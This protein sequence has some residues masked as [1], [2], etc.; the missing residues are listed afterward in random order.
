MKATFRFFTVPV[1]SYLSTRCLI[2]LLSQILRNIYQCLKCLPWELITQYNKV[3]TTFETSIP[4]GNLIQIATYHLS[5]TS[6]LYDYDL[7]PLRTE[8][9]TI[10]AVILMYLKPG[11]CMGSGLGN[12]YGDSQG[13]A[14]KALSWGIHQMPWKARRW[15]Y[16][17]KEIHQRAGPLLQPRWT[18]SSDCL[19]GSFCTQAGLFSFDGRADQHARQTAQNQETAHYISLMIWLGD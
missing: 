18:S 8:S 11:Q 14:P 17:R 4:A 6:D 13:T 12:M 9:R 5:E 15:T 16:R 7:G 10:E 19:T 2:L 3:R 1:I